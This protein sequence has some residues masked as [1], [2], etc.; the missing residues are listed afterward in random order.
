MWIIYVIV[1]YISMSKVAGPI[2][3]IKIV[4]FKVTVLLKSISAMN[5]YKS[6][7]I[8]FAILIILQ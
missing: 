3:I 5:V 2:I 4:S 6:T 1:Q 8:S 7:L